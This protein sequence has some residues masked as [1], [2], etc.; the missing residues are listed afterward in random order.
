MIQHGELLYEEQPEAPKPR[1][2]IKGPVSAL[3]QFAQAWGR[4][5]GFDVDAIPVFEARIWDTV[6]AYEKGEID[7]EELDGRWEY[8]PQITL[9]FE[10]R[11]KID[12]DTHEL[13]GNPE[14]IVMQYVANVDSRMSDDTIAQVYERV[15]ETFFK[16]LEKE[17]PVP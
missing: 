8:A 3:E 15:K 1:I 14:E 9:G 10:H 12:L 2:G 17:F 4:E 13:F 11:L 6:R 7:I 5:R 16:I